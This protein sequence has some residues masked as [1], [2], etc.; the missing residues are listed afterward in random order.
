[1]ADEKVFTVG[2]LVRLK[3]G[4]PLMTVIYMAPREEDAFNVQ[5]TWYSEVANTYNTAAFNE[6]T[7]DKTG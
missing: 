5:C 1:M 3:S 6:N 7:L 4:G 2:D